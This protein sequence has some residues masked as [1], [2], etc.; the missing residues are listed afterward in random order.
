[1]LQHTCHWSSE[2]LW[3][4]P[5][6]HHQNWSIYYIFLLTRTIQNFHWTSPW[7]APTLDPSQNLLWKALNV[8]LVILLPVVQVIFLIYG[9][10]RE[11]ATC[12][13]WVKRN[14]CVHAAC[15]RYAC[16]LYGF[17][18]L[19]G[20]T[21]GSRN[22]QYINSLAPERPGCHFKTAIF[23]LVLLIGFLR[24]SND[25]ALRW[26]PWDLTDDKSTLVQVMAWCRQAASHY[27]SQCWP[28]SMLPYGF[29]KPQWVN[30]SP[31]G[32]NGRHFGR[33]QFQMH[34]LEWKW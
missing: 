5:S 23:N 12:V 28:S 3:N 8:W 20:G 34:F 21:A 14:V 31:P 17:S 29:T 1:M 15:C 30:S 26:K 16:V 24:S 7:H 11:L 13:K 6:G 4:L 10:D 32:Q 27:L 2:L 33:G 22:Q 18:M 25:N 9:D 19:W